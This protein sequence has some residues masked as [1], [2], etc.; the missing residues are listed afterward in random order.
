MAGKKNPKQENIG[1]PKKTKTTKVSEY[2]LLQYN[3]MQNSRK[4][5]KVWGL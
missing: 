2:K 5:M 3:G 1:K 4:M